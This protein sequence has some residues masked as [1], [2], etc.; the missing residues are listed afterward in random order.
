MSVERRTRTPKG[1]VKIAVKG[2]V[3][4]TFTLPFVPSGTFTTGIASSMSAKS[5]SLFQSMNTN[6]LAAVGTAIM[7]ITFTVM[8]VGMLVTKV[9]KVTPFSSSVA[10]GVVESS[11]LALTFCWPLPSASTDAPSFRPG[12]ILW[13]GPSFAPPGVAP[14]F[15]VA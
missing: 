6:S 1:A 13:L 5:P 4:G 14:S 7:F 10:G 8:L 11:P 9:G 3:T 2:G 12:T 15:C